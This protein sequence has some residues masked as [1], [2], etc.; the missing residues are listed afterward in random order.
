MESD[1]SHDMTCL[2]PCLSCQ[3]C[4][5]ASVECTSNCSE[6]TRNG[7]ENGSCTHACRIYGTVFN[8]QKRVTTSDKLVNTLE[9]RPILK[10]SSIAEYLLAI[11]PSS[12]VCFVPKCRIRVVNIRPP[13]H[14]K[15][16]PRPS[17]HWCRP[18]PMHNAFPKSSLLS[19]ASLVPVE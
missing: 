6:T 10:A 13:I 7:S 11:M 17:T 3:Q 2:L 9:S 16:A 19:L 18:I 12:F 4:N 8:L 5:S 15:N 1:S 14:P